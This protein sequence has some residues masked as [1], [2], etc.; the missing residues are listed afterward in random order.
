VH[1]YRKIL[2]YFYNKVERKGD[3][4]EGK[5]AFVTKK[6]IISVLDCSA[7]GFNFLSFLYLI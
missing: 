5:E 4:Q 7:K 6:I 1:F 3:A 2:L